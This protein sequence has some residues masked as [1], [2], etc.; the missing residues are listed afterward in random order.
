ME[1]KMKFRKKLNSHRMDYH[2]IHRS[3]RVDC[4]LAQRLYFL[5]FNSEIIHLADP[6]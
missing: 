4:N 5:N 6:K 2:E 1:Q 3:Q